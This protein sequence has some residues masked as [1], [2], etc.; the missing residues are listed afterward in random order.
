MTTKLMDRTQKL[1]VEKCDELKELLLSKNRKYGNAVM[2]PV[3]VFSSDDP[4]R[5]INS[6][7]DEKLTRVAQRADDEDEDP[8]WDICGYLI[9]KKVAQTIQRETPKAEI[10]K[11]RPKSTHTRVGTLEPFHRT[12]ADFGVK[13]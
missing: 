10:E 11:G 5:V 6:R 8:E 2:E 12:H 3:Q 4:V 9:L 1:I 13:S 7:I